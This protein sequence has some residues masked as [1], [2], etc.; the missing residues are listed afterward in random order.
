MTAQLTKRQLLM[1]RHII[2]VARAARRDL[3]K[4]AD[5]GTTARPTVKQI[6]D[7]LDALLEI[8]NEA[9]HVLALRLPD[10]A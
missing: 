9:V 4:N 10:A 2:H 3:G 6:N 5:R 1:V 8:E 7:T